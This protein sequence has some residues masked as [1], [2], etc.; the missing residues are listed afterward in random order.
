MNPS[1]P[2]EKRILLIGFV[3]LILFFLILPTLMV[4]PMSISETRY[5]VLPPKGFTL[6][7]FL[8]FFTDPRWLGPTLLSLRVA[9][10]S[11]VLSVVL[12]T[13]ASLALVRG[14]LPGKRVIYIML[15][16][17]M[18]IPV[19]VIGFAAY[20]MFVRFHLIGT[21]IGIV[22]AH[23]IICIPFSVVVISANLQRVDISL[24]LAARNL[25]ASARQ[26]FFRITIPSIKPGIFAASLFCF[27]ES[28]DELIMTMFIIGTTKM[29][30]PLRI[31][32][33]IRFRISPVIAAASTVFVIVATLAIVIST[34]IDKK[35]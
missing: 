8:Q 12:G 19:I 33:E 17:P 1:A 16:S 13:L 26:A 27:V 15:M 22:L 31:F 35:K 23:C 7:W 4:I 9:L 21:T 14:R 11:A 34:Y 30:L 18:M 29:T 20:G 32:T 24:E 3:T 28:L 10:F 25:G 2:Q 6:K 5:L